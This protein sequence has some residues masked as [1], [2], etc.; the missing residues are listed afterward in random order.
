MEGKIS[1]RRGGEK[2][3]EEGKEKEEGQKRQEGK[4]EAGK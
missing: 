3:T 2:M 4:K 1:G